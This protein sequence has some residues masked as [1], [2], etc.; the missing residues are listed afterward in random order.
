MPMI[1]L[2]GHSLAFGVELS[3]VGFFFLVAVVNVDGVLFCLTGFAVRG[4]VRVFVPPDT[5]RS[6]Q[7]RGGKT[8]VHRAMGVKW[9]MRFTY[10]HATAVAD[11]LDLL[12][13]ISEL[14]LWI[15]SVGP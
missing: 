12:N 10:H 11:L 3:C 5:E 1:R 8:Y 6:L 13:R 15:H 4:S 9:E 14:S 2:Q 7:R